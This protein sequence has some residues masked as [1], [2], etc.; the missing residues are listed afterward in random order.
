MAF[1]HSERAI[2][3]EGKYEFFQGLLDTGSEGTLI[4]EDPNTSV[5]CESETGL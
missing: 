1:Y 4:P 2:W 3:G 5:G